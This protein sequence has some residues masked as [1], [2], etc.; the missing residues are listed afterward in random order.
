M[1][2]PMT[3]GQA[4]ATWPDDDRW[5]AERL[6]VVATADRRYGLQIVSTEFGIVFQFT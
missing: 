6:S 5:D 2:P 1:C 3:H 4:L